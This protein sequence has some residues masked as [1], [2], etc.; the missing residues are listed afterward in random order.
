MTTT[1]NIA[2]RDA[3]IEQ[4]VAVQVP[5]RV[6]GLVLVGAPRAD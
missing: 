1:V 2:R 5:H 3:L 4:Q 6:D